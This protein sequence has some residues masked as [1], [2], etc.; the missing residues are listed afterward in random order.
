[1]VNLTVT[2]S[3]CAS[4]S[5]EFDIWWG[6]KEQL[7]LHV[8]VVCYAYLRRWNRTGRDIKYDYYRITRLSNERQ[9]RLI[10]CGF[11]S[12]NQRLT[13]SSD[14]CTCNSHRVLLHRHR[15]RHHRCLRRRHHRRE[16]TVCRRLLLA[17]KRYK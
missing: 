11:T 7:L 1:M 15:R 10:R 4:K 2:K 17:C 3:D 5:W 12:M 9:Q 16:A 6:T 14:H 8:L 13:R